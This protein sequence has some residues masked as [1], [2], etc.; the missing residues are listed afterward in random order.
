VAKDHLPVLVKY[1]QH[2]THPWL[3]LEEVPQRQSTAIAMGKTVMGIIKMSA[4]TH[5][6]SLKD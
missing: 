3:N 6:S 2:P 1:A 4:R 5:S